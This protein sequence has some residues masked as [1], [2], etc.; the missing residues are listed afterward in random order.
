MIAG[1]IIDVYR[2]G[3]EGGGLLRE[4]VEQG[5]VLPVSVSKKMDSLAADFI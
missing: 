4:G 1:I 2:D 3:L 5:V